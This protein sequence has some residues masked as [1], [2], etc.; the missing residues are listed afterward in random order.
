MNDLHF[1]DAQWAHGVWGV[2]LLAVVLLVLEQRGTQ[3]LARLLSSIMQSRLVARPP[4]SRRAMRAIGLGVACFCLVIALMRPQFGFKYI[5]TPR[6]GAEIM[7]CLDVS[8]SMLAE[9]VA[10]NRL[11]RAKAEIQDLLTY[12]DEDHVGLTAFAGKATVLC[13]MTPDFG[14]LRLILDSAD[15]Q[16]V[17]RGGTNL[18][19]P[20]RKALDGFRGES[21]LSRA[22]ILI[23]DGEDHDSFALDA[24]KT[25]AERGIRI[26]TIGFGSETGSEVYV[27]DPRTAARTKL[28]DGNGQPVISRLD[29]DL[30]R[31]I[32]QTT[33]SVYVPAGTGVLDLKSIYDAHI[34]PMTRGRLDNRGRTIKQEGYQWMVLAALIV[35]IA[36][37]VAPWRARRAQIAAVAILLSATTAFAQDE[38]LLPR[39]VYN[40]GLTQLRADDLD[41]ADEK[42][43]MAREQAGADGVVRYRASYNLGWVAVKRAD[44]VIEE[45]GEEALKHLNAAAEWFREAVRLQ[46]DET[47]A[48]ENLE[49]VTRRALALAD[50]L[51]GQDERD[52][53][54]RLDELIGRQRQL[55]SQLQGTVERAA[56]SDATQMRGEFRALEAEQRHNLATL[57]EIAEMTRREWGQLDGTAAEERTPE[58]NLRHAQ[59]AGVGAYL[60]L[61]QQRVGQTR[62]ELRRGQAGRAYRRAS[63][64]LEQLKRARDQLRNIVEMLTA[65]LGDAMYLTRLSAAEP[66]QRPLWLTPD[67]LQESAEAVRQRVEEMVLRVDAGLASQGDKDEKAQ[68]VLATLGEARPL[69]GAAQDSFAA[70]VEAIV[71]QRDTDAYEAE[72][73]GVKALRR[74]RELFLDIKGL[75]EVMYADQKMMHTA[76]TDGKA[77]VEEYVPL[78][79]QLQSGNMVRARRLDKLI[80]EQTAELPEGEQDSQAQQQAQQQAKQMELAKRLLSEA[81]SSFVDIKQRVDEWGE[82]SDELA[83]RNG[84]DHSME[85]LEALRRLFYSIIEHLRETA[86]RQAQLT[87]E[88]RD[89]AA[90]TDADPLQQRTGPLAPRQTELAQISQQIAEALK[91]Q[92]QQSPAAVAGQSQ[93]PQAAQQS[94]EAAQ[95]F[96]Q[97][98]E[99][100]AAAGESMN[101]ATQQLEADPAA[102]SAAHEHQ[103]AALQK[104]I[105]ALALLTPPQQGQDQTDPKQND[106]GEQDEDE[107]DEQEQQQQQA[108]SM[109]MARMLQSVRD[110]EAERQRR[111]LQKPAGYAPVEKDW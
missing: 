110:R 58:Q 43:A 16:S 39:D 49:I 11:E 61:A 69:L 84:I 55:A 108:Q 37:L 18:E 67:Y 103:A 44:Q 79:G 57:D 101:Q 9:D 87:D 29:G 74:A 88:T 22:V 34:A 99:L 45:N 97:A 51:A 3:R 31:K 68:K 89:V 17:A 75:I 27:T 48:R 33:E 5:E 28:S 80:D 85:V 50:A 24:A 7:I 12:L 20:I 82:S 59:L 65:V 70:A 94:Q 98:G 107:K 15:P 2:L 52:L 6:V 86:R 40:E 30:L 62:R 21:D 78:F 38:T 10:P 72:A 47:A 53:S 46:P 90:L 8:R 60:Q 36:A 14:F 35:L 91:K 54:V 1:A 95:K 71:S 100:V 73:R 76:V 104:L 64:G 42:L 19:A 32:S 77:P 26:I 109:D 25:A 92:S 66:A 96:A 102:P 63:A 93:D 13:P 106:Q 4:R 56:Q 41:T 105:E 81:R 111:R 23:T 83:L